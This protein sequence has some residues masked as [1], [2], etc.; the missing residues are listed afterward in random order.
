MN[1]FLL[2]VTS[3][4]RWWEM[5]FEMDDSKDGD[6]SKNWNSTTHVN[7]R[8]GYWVSLSLSGSPRVIL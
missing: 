4:K 5:T 2:V 1:P 8:C 3:K 6:T 7:M